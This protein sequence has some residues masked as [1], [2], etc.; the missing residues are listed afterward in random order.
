MRSLARWLSLGL[1]LLPSFARAEDPTPGELI[2]LAPSIGSDDGSIKSYVVRGRLWMKGTSGLRF[3]AVY[4]APDRYALTVCTEDG[5]PVSLTVDERTLLYDPAP[6]KVRIASGKLALGVVGRKDG[7]T[8]GFMGQP[9]KSKRADHIDLKSFWELPPLSDLRVDRL[10]DG[11]IRLSV[12]EDQM[13]MESTV[14]LTRKTPFT[15]F[16]MIRKGRDLVT[17][18]EIEVNEAIPGD[19]EFV[20]PEKPKLVEILRERVGNDVVAVEN[21]VGLASF[22]RIVTVRMTDEA[23]K[24]RE[25]LKTSSFGLFTVDSDEV[26]ANDRRYG[27]TLRELLPQSALIIPPLV[28]IPGG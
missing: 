20:F 11:R 3:R 12:V 9:S 17:L 23:P 8:C 27:P 7:F 26:R 28:D 22:F 13:R 24:A 16:R 25:N 4:R 14:D 18:D 19:N 2:K 10:E 21:V 5:V 6:P 1:F 15:T